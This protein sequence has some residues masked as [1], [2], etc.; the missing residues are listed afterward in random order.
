MAL[1]LLGKDSLELRRQDAISLRCCFP[2]ENEFV[3]RLTHSRF[4]EL[5]EL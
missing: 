1:V 2:E 5:P 4:T 3:D